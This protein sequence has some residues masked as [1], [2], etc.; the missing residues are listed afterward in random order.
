[1]RIFPECVKDFWEVC[2]S[3]PTSYSKG[4]ID[5]KLNA[6][7]SSVNESVR[8]VSLVTTD[9]SSNVGSQI[10]IAHNDFGENDLY[11]KEINGEPI[12][13]SNY[14]RG[15]GNLQLAETYTS[16]TVPDISFMDGARATVRW[17]ILTTG[18]SGLYYFIIPAGSKAIVTDYQGG[19]EGQL[20]HLTDTAIQ[21]G[22]TSAR[23]RTTTRYAATFTITANEN[24]TVV[25]FARAD[26]VMPTLV[27]T[28]LDH[29]VKVHEQS[30][31]DDVKKLFQSSNM[32][33]WEGEIDDIS[34]EGVTSYTI[35]NHT[36]SELIGLL[37]NGT[38]VLL[39]MYTTAD[40][41]A[42]TMISQKH[43]WN[44]YFSQVGY[45]NMPGFIEKQVTINILEI[46][47][48][49]NDS[50]LLTQ[51]GINLDEISALQGD[52]A[53]LEYDLDTHTADSTVHVTASEKNTWNSK[54]D[55]SALEPYLLEAD[56]NVLYGNRIDV[57]EQQQANVYTKDDIDN[58]T[59]ATAAALNDLNKRINA[60]L[61]QLNQ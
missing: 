48:G 29:G 60:I 8:D 4:E 53:T 25:W 32:V 12:I 30:L 40:A 52:V 21:K 16:S 1:M 26:G 61:E 23:I 36:Y 11:F 39:N 42:L 37:D 15:N 27:I 57:L 13:S 45:S 41:L 3:T 35:S 6:I 24:D 38:R 10:H 28:N 58:L 19:T 7:Q 43:L 47:Q 59:T 2:P 5:E 46:K 20:Y 56:A 9:S 17:E 22:A 14:W 54:L 44:Y 31:G 34:E 50:I 33:V 49:T 51:E 55:A 18:G